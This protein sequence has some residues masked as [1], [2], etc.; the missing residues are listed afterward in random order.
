MF[1]ADDFLA[2]HVISPK[3]GPVPSRSGGFSYESDGASTSVGSVRFCGFLLDIAD[4][5]D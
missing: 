4:E 3:N 5:A 1:S 2:K